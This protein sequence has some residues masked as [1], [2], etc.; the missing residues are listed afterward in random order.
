MNDIVTGK[1]TDAQIASWLTAMAMKGETADEITVAFLRKNALHI[2]CS[3][4]AAIDI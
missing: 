2:Q 1:C 4:E 3:D